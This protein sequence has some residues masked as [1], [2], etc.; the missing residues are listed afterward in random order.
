MSPHSCLEDIRRNLELVLE[1]TADTSYGEF[2][3]DVRTQYAV[4]RCFEIAGEATKRT[5]ER[6]RLACPS[7]PWRSMAAMRDKL[8]QGYATVDASVLWAT[9]QDDVPRAMHQLP[10]LQQKLEKSGPDA[11]D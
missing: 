8:I 9:I 10:E 1:F 4:I 6:V 11:A 5:P 3:R 2:A 7:F